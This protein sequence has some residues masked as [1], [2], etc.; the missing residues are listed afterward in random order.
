MRKVVAVIDAGYDSYKYEQA[1]LERHGY[2]LKV[3]SGNEKSQEEK[4]Q[5]ARKAVGIF[6]RGTEIDDHFLQ[7]CPDLKAVVR[8]G[9][10]YDNIDLESA[11]KRGI[12]VAIVKGYGSHSVSDH[13]LALM[14]ACARSIPG[15]QKIIRTDFGKPPVKRIIEFHQKTRF[16]YP[17]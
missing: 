9:V 15:G 6:I 14:F 13:A 10:G 1:L 3:Y 16:R 17:T 4:I 8:Y 12:K 5:F 11:S 2:Q 7:E